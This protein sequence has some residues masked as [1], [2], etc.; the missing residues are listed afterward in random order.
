M[1]RRGRWSWALLLSWTVFRYRVQQ[2]VL[3][4]LV[5]VTLF[6]TAVACHWRELPQVSFLSRQTFC[7]DKLTR[8]C[9]DRRCLLSRQKYVCRDRHIFVATKLL[10]L[11]RQTYLQNNSK[12][13]TWQS[14]KNNNIYISF[15]KPPHRTTQ[16][17]IL[18]NQNK[19]HI[20]LQKST[21][22]RPDKARIYLQSNTE[23]KPGKAK[24]IT[25]LPPEQHR[26]KKRPGEAKNIT[27]LPPEQHRRKGNIH[28]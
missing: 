6:R 8:V 16:K 23:E 15:T 22:E 24:N 26:K 25:Y 27:Y 4:A 11:S 12:G 20:Y 2:L 28:F 18:T 9:R 5:F 17:K 14:Q 21:D 1:V 13:E 10:Y 3:R 19:S 7:R